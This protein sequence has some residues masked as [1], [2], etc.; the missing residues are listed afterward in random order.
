MKGKGGGKHEQCQPEFLTSRA[1]DGFVVGPN[2][3][4]DKHNGQDALITNFL[5]RTGHCSP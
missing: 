2:Q 5:L 3:R 1:Y 4:L